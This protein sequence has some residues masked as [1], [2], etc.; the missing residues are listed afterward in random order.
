MNYLSPLAVLFIPPT[1]SFLLPL[2]HTLWAHRGQSCAA[3]LTVHWLV[4]MLWHAMPLDLQSTILF[5]SL[6]TSCLPCC[7]LAGSCLA[8]A[9]RQL[10]FLPP[11]HIKC[12]MLLYQSL[13]CFWCGCTRWPQ[14]TV[15]ITVFHRLRMLKA[16]ISRRTEQAL[17]LSR[18]HNEDFA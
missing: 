15:F 7:C 5:S 18:N 12:C 17:I 9:S 13:A 14:R 10:V 16:L 3:L 8:D 1:V 11:C 2:P 4:S 6:I